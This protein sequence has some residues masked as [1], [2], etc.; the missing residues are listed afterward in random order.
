MDLSRHPAPQPDTISLTTPTNGLVNTAVA[1]HLDKGTMPPPQP[2]VTL[3]ENS[4][5]GLRFQPDSGSDWDGQLNETD[6]PRMPG[7]LWSG[8]SNMQT[9]LSQQLVVARTRKNPINLHNEGEIV[10]KKRAIAGPRHM[11]LENAVEKEKTTRQKVLA[12]SVE[13]NKQEVE[14]D[15]IRRELQKE[16]SERKRQSEQELAETKSFQEKLS[17]LENK[18]HTHIEE[19]D[20]CEAQ[21]ADQILQSEEEK[22]KL[23]RTNDELRQQIQDLLANFDQKLA[24]KIEEIVAAKGLPNEPKVAD[25]EALRRANEMMSA[26][27]RR[28]EEENA[29]LQQNNTDFQRTIDDLKLQFERDLSQRDNEIRAM[30]QKVHAAS[31]S[32]APAPL[33]PMAGPSAAQQQNLPNARSKSSQSTP[34]TP[35]GTPPET[36]QPGS[37]SVPTG[38]TQST[39]SETAKSPSQTQQP[40]SSSTSTGRTESPPQMR[41]P[42]SS[43]APTSSPQSIPSTP[44]TRQ[45][46]Q[47]GSQHTRPSQRFDMLRSQGVKIPVI[48]LEPSHLSQVPGTSGSNGPTE[49]NPG[50]AF[51]P[52]D[53]QNM[54]TMKAIIGEAIKQIGVGE[55]TSTKRR[56]SA[57]RTRVAAGIKEQQAKMT[58][59]ADKDWK[60][61]D[62][63]L[64]LHRHEEVAA[65][66]EGG[67]GPGDSGKLDFNK[68]WEN[69][70]WNKTVL[71]KVYDK[72]IAACRIDG[73]WNLPDVS[74]EYVMGELWGHLKQGREAW[75]K[76]Q[77]RYL[78][79]TKK[80][81]TPQEVMLQVGTSTT[82]KMKSAASRARRECKYE[83]RVGIV[84]KVIALKAHDAPDLAAWKY[85]RD[86]LEKLS[87][88]G[89]SSEEEGTAKVGT[90][91]MCIFWVK[92]CIWRAPEIKNYFAYIDNAGE[93]EAIRGTR[94]SKT[95][96]RFNSEE[97]GTSPAPNGLPRKMYNPTWLENEEKTRPG[98]VVEKLKVS[99]EAFELLTHATRL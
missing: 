70:R 16:R 82:M 45:T 91:N 49:F 6:I 29:E 58:K 55:V 54:E 87:L 3:S 99:Q 41:H 19:S 15:L 28:A 80:L 13:R 56:R 31:S 53:P 77:S 97:H 8:P 9:N 36:Q 89:M 20:L 76:V 66:E 51:N 22:E 71:R 25:N 27:A 34:S 43:C 32:S 44:Q 86:M 60:A 98:W 88:D 69:S 1:I 10:T 68:G 92:L 95:T 93:S 4:I 17:E 5:V 46:E 23:T 62:Y 50:V 96:P 14:L 2:K 78:F 42:N 35:T 30:R 26:A 65:F 90:K 75:S 67:E 47:P 12:V 33:G 40:A 7:S 94:G 18:Y 61:N 39:P 38:P 72:I 37:S 52:N 64:Q 79:A 59:V 63:R 81:E 11:Q 57:V 73:G 24:S 85:F 74:E 21:M 84:E 83:R 48:P